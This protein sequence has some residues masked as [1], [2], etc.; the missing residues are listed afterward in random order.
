MAFLESL[1][2]VANSAGES[3]AEAVARQIEEVIARRKIA[4][5]S[6]L[7]TKEEMQERLNVARGTINEAFRLLKAREV[8]QMRPG[9]KGGIFVA[10]AKPLVRFGDTVLRLDHSARTLEEVF[11]VRNALDPWIA[12]DAA[13]SRSAADIKELRRIVVEMETTIDAPMKDR[14]KLNWRLHRRIAKSAGNVLLQ[15]IYLAMLDATEHESIEI[16]KGAEPTRA[17]HIQRNK[18]H[19]QLVEAIAAGDADKAFRL[20]GD[21]HRFP[22]HGIKKAS[23]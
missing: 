7:G 1:T 20:G 17:H 13:E 18:I 19:N 21:A 6:P 4:P 23:A 22:V 8:I 16:V 10:E 3:R 15:S 14:M 11:V 2:P 5:L 12:K 9:P